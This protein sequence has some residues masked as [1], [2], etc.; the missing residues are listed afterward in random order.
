MGFKELI[1]GQWKTQSKAYVNGWI[2]NIEPKESQTPVESATFATPTDGPGRFYVQVRCTDLRIRYEVE[3]LT[4]WQPVLQS[5]IQWRTP[6]DTI[7]V[8]ATFGPS[9][10]R[11]LGESSFKT[12]AAENVALSG[13]LPLNQDISLLVGLLREPGNSLLDRA[14]NF[15]SSLAEFTHVPQLSTA[16]P[17]A[18]K[19]A[20]GV[21]KLLGND[22]SQGILALSLQIDATKPASGY[23]VCSSADRQKRST[24]LMRVYK[25]RLQVWAANE[26]GKSEWQY[27]T[28]FDYFLLNVALEPPQPNRWRT[29][30]SILD[31]VQAS[32]RKLDEANTS[33]ALVG[34]SIEMLEA[35]RLARFSPDLIFIDQKSTQETIR[36]EWDTSVANRATTIAKTHSQP[37]WDKKETTHEIAETMTKPP[38]LNDKLQPNPFDAE[39]FR[40]VGKAISEKISAI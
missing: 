12:L 5:Q 7:S 2:T 40:A 15:L 33:G 27:V 38:G 30:P 14:T 20:E 23:Y 31:K 22:D 18:D 32:T 34:A 35:A 17:I 29:L 25:E 16:A 13:E 4:Q 26:Q 24:D 9:T 10:F 21:D 1:Q 36:Q 37:V 8:S 3:K 39:S 28:E 19:I 6:N 11:S